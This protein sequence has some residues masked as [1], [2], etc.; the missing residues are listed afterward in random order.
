MLLARA[1]S[2]APKLKERIRPIDTN[3]MICRSP[4]TRPVFDMQAV[5]KKLTFVVISYGLAMQKR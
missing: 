3:D 5:S 4:M 2:D 1:R